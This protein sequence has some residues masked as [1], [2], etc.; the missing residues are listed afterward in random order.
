MLLNTEDFSSIMLLSLTCTHVHIQTHT[1]IVYLTML[2][3][4]QD[5]Q[6]QTVEQLMTDEL[7]RMW[8]W[9]ISRFYPLI[10]LE[11]LRNTTKDLSQGSWCPGQDSNKAPSEYKS[12]VLPP[13]PTY[14]VKSHSSHYRQCN[15]FF[16]K[17]NHIRIV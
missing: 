2:S 12:G 6:H 5:I 15:G 16:L 11:R 1:F 7:R 17:L 10:H 9:P 3:V 8:L 14:S 4:V 13:E